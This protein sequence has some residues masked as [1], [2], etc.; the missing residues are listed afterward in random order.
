MHA[1][2]NNTPSSPN[3]QLRQPLRPITGSSPL[4]SDRQQ[5]DG[6]RTSTTARSKLSAVPFKPRQR[7]SAVLPWRRRQQ[8]TTS[9]LRVTAKHGQQSVAHQ[10]STHPTSMVTPEDAVFIDHS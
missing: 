5:R 3:Q 8:A 6:G 7:P 2:H 10:I 9:L 4:R 1:P